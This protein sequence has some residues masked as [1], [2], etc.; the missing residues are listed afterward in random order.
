MKR[1]L[2]GCYKGKKAKEA[3]K[4]K[5]KVNKDVLCF[6]N[7]K[8]PLTDAEIRLLKKT[9]TKFIGPRRQLASTSTRSELPLL[10]QHTELLKDNLI[11]PQLQK[12]IRE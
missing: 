6:N 10:P 4:A 5:M 7:V 11:P 1:I 2:V 12:C 3:R 8:Y 9:P